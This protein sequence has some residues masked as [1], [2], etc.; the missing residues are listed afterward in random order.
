MAIDMDKI[1]KEYWKYNMIR[2]FGLTSWAYTDELFLCIDI[3][4]KKVGNLH[5]IDWSKYGW[6]YKNATYLRHLQGKPAKTSWPNST[7][8]VFDKI[9]CPICQYGLVQREGW[10]W[11]YTNA[12]T[13]WCAWL[14]YSWFIDFVPSA[15]LFFYERIYELF[16]LTQYM[17]PS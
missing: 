17:P 16:G 3:L 8:F 15:N 4:T 1:N 6:D 5:I 2:D 11:D 12:F 9:L 10:P 14:I 13:T 7:R